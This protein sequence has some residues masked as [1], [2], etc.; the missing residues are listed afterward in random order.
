MLTPM[1]SVLVP[2]FPSQ[3]VTEMSFTMPNNGVTPSTVAGV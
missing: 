2:V 3:P 1:Y